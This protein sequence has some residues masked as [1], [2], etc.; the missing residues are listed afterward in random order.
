LF[1]GTAI[2]APL[3]SAEHDRSNPVRPRVLVEYWRAQVVP[4]LP[5][6]R[7]TVVAV[8]QAVSAPIATRQLADLGA[9]V[10]NIERPGR[11]SGFG[12]D[13][14]WAGGKAYD[15]LVQAE[16]G[17]M[18]LT[19]TPDAAAK[20]GISLAD[21][22]AGGYAFSIVPAALFRRQR[23]GDASEV[24]VAVF[25]AMSEWLGRS[26]ARLLDRPG[27]GIAEI[28]MR[29]SSGRALLSTTSHRQRSR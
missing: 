27:R 8:E 7:I 24:D 28:E 15:L 23:T 1:S 18:S 20:A 11:V 16:T 3:I 26:R 12:A 5:L 13:G 2:V 14:P 4:M 22:A 9:R 29:L 17:L 6:T 21:I 25:D 19:G 10:V